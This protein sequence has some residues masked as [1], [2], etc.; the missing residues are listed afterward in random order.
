[1]LGELWAARSRGRCLFV[2]TG[3]QGMASALR[4]AVASG[5]GSAAAC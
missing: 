2:L 5:A 1:M 4:Q 3:Q